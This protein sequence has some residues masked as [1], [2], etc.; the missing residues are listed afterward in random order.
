MATSGG[1]YTGLFVSFLLLALCWKI[2]EAR[3]RFTVYHSYGRLMPEKRPICILEFVLLC[4]EKRRTNLFYHEHSIV[5]ISTD[6][7]SEI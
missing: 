3:T 1:I 5:P 7:T 2:R 4:F 6:I